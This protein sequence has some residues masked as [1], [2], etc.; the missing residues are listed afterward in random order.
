L[1]L[2]RVAR[3]G[4]S[5]LFPPPTGTGRF[6]D[7][8]RRFRTLYTALERIA[9]YA[10]TLQYFRPNLSARQA[11]ADLRYEDVTTP[12]VTLRT[13]VS[14]RELLTIQV[15][16]TCTLLDLRQ[17]QVLE[18][19]TDEIAQDLAGLGLTDFDAANLLGQDRRVT[20]TVAAWAHASG[21]DGLLSPSRL[22][23]E[24]TSCVLFDRARPRV[25]SRT[26]IDLTDS[27]LRAV[28]LAFHLRVRG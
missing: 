9:A 18:Q 17:F 7:P 25:R 24:W 4:H 27:D 21:F 26:P 2:Y 8:A 14:T 23:P 28:A 22:A 19:A 10:E 1:A 15:P 13:W 11:L 12:P 5:G 16:S 3:E 6:D 20:Q